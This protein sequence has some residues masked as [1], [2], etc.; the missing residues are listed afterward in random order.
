MCPLEAT[1]AP[2]P[3]SGCQRVVS[4]LPVALAVRAR[5][6]KDMGRSSR[7]AFTGHAAAIVVRRRGG[8][9]SIDPGTA[10]GEANSVRAPLAPSPPV[11]WGVRERGG[12]CCGPRAT[13]ASA[14]RGNAVFGDCEICEN[15]V[16]LVSF[17]KLAPRFLLRS[18]VSWI[19]PT[20]Q[21]HFASTQ[22]RQQLRTTP[23]WH[24]LGQPAPWGTQRYHYNV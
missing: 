14:V 16:R 5:S 19:S 1:D 9:T 10:P 24:H 22:Q 2:A 15:L 11:R 8:P 21:P 12:G 20:T 23:M 7:P 3:P 6:H 17:Q 4:G 18:R 13:P